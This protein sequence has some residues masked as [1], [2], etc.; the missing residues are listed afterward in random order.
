MGGS[1]SDYQELNNLKA[2]IKQKETEIEK[3]KKSKV[4]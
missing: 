3:L 4:A 1:K 2:E